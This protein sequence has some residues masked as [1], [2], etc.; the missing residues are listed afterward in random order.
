MGSVVEP[1]NAAQATM[2]LTLSAEVLATLTF[3]I[4][5]AVSKALLDVAQPLQSAAAAMT[6][7]VS[8]PSPSAAAAAVPE[9]QF[10]PD[11]IPLS[12][13]EVNRGLGP[14]EANPSSTNADQTVLKT[15]NNAVQRVTS[16]LLPSAASQS[17]NLFLSAAVPLTHL[18][19]KKVKKEIW[20]NEYV[21]LALLLN[22][23]FTQSDDHYTF[24]VEE[25]D[26]GKPALVLLL[27]PKWQTGQSNEQWVSGFQTFVAIS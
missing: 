17:E 18:V 23:S 9:V 6:V 20:S 25:G 3:S 4:S 15:V 16:S 24:R 14:V 10:V 22:S 19:P 13:S 12:S 27:N 7:P 2:Q 11:P 26:G 5:A 1:T 21:D 8:H